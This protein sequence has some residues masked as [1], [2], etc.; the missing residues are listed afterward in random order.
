VL[1]TVPWIVG[2]SLSGGHLYALRVREREAGIG[3]D[4][5]IEAL[6]EE[7][8]GAS[9]HFIPL[10]TM[11]YYSERYKLLPESFP[12][13]LAMYERSLSLPIWQGMSDSQADRVCQAVL[14]LVRPR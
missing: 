6:A 10:H 9:V 1:T 7:G 14:G 8:V 5:L 3:R 11:P 2:M 12:N 13:A 4:A